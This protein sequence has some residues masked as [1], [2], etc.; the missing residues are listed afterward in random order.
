MFKYSLTKKK[1]KRLVKK[2]TPNRE[3]LHD[4]CIPAAFMNGNYEN[5]GN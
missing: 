3:I 2:K 1:K 4:Y 5:Y